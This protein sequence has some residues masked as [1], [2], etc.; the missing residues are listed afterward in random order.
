MVWYGRD[1]TEGSLPVGAVAPGIAEEGCGQTGPFF[2][3][4]EEEA[5]GAVCVYCRANGLSRRRVRGPPAISTTHGEEHGGMLNS[6]EINVSEE[7]KHYKKWPFL[8]FKIP[9]TLTR[10]TERTT[11]ARTRKQ[12]PPTGCSRR[13]SSGVTKNPPSELK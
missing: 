3:C 8:I 11:R 1:S 9:K 10:Q 12:R 4:A 5:G 2:Q 13:A 6:S 7:R